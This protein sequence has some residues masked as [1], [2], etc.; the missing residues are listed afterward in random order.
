MCFVQHDFD[1]EAEDGEEQQVLS[2]LPPQGKQDGGDGEDGG[3]DLDYD[4]EKQEREEEEHEAELNEE[5]EGEGDQEEHMGQAGQVGGA[6]MSSAD[7]GIENDDE[8]GLG[9][10]KGEGSRGGGG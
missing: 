6:T 5:E 3:E 9:D 1:A 8:E 7:R 2:I 10:S 4:A